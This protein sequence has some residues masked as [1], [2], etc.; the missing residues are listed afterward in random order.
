MSTESKTVTEDSQTDLSEDDDESEEFEIDEEYAED[1]SN[2]LKSLSKY[3]N[4]RMERSAPPSA[5]PSDSV[6]YSITACLALLETLPNV[7]E[8]LYKKALKRILEDPKWRQSFIVVIPER[9]TWLL[10]ML[11]L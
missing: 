11:E 5:P 6:D 4:W 3:L 10:E 1:V 9:R 7:P 2:G 8:E